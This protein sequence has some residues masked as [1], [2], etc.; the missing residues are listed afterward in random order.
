[1]AGAAREQG[2]RMGGSLQV[3]AMDARVRVRVKARARARAGGETSFDPGPGRVP[4]QEQEQGWPERR[5]PPACPSKI[6]ANGGTHIRGPWH[7]PPIHTFRAVPVRQA[8]PPMRRPQMSRLQCW[9]R[10]S[11]TAALATPRALNHSLHPWPLSPLLSPPRGRTRTT[12]GSHRTTARPLIRP[13][14]VLPARACHPAR[15]PER[16][17]ACTRAHS[18]VAAR[19]FSL[20]PVQLSSCQILIATFLSLPLSLS[21][22]AGLP[23]S[24][25]NESLTSSTALGGG[26]A[27]W[28][29]FSAEMPS[30]LGGQTRRDVPAMRPMLHSGS[31]RH[32][33][34][35][36][37]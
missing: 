28:V 5:G 3:R 30:G 32:S 10:P 27:I 14:G 36:H 17:V 19:L 4:E 20:H 37:R 7:L 31:T 29:T 23:P 6:L 2:A 8:P 18:V 13:P 35:H 16:R 26:G 24:R 22:H 11:Q 21:S 15:V 12:F 25:P 34:I 1:M 33:F 9:P